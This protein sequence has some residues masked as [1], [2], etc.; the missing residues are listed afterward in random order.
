MTYQN[1]PSER[2]DTIKAIFTL[3]NISQNDS[4]VTCILSFDKY[5][6]NI[7]PVSVTFVNVDLSQPIILDNGFSILDSVGYYARGTSLNIEMNQK[8]LIEKVDSVPQMLAAMAAKSHRDYKSVKSLLQDYISV[9]AITDLMNRSFSISPA[10]EIVPGFRWMN[11]VTMITKAPIEVKT[12]Y[13]PEKSSGDSLTINTSLL[14]ASADS[15][16]VLKGKGNGTL[17]M[18][19]STGLPLRSE[20]NAEMVTATSEYDVTEREHLKLEQVSSKH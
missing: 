6:V 4:T 13:V 11:T 12:F 8:G 9:N 16:G 18:S 19:Y 10:K 15:S 14:F 20:S 3:K 5:V 17:L 7:P 2:A 1:M